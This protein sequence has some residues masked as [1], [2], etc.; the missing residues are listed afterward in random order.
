MSFILEA[1]KKSE[2]ARQRQT[3]PGLAG[4]PEKT[5]SRRTVV[6]PWVIGALLLVNAIIIGVVL[7]RDGPG[8]ATSPGPSASTSTSAGPT[9]APSPPGNSLRETEAP[10]SGRPPVPQASPP[11][12]GPGT[13][14]SPEPVISGPEPQ[15][16]T[17]GAAVRSLA[18]EARSPGETS[19][20]ARSEPR[21][22]SRTATADPATPV[23]APATTAPD[24]R[25]E[26]DPPDETPQPDLPD[27]QALYLSGELSGSPIN[28]DLHV[29]F[30]D[31]GRRVV[32][33]SGKRYREGDEIDAGLTVE[34][35]IPA[36][37]ILQRRGR[38]YLL[39]AN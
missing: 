38:N 22:V 36:G 24:P 13:T 26:P 19:P 37:V 3:G 30:P 12:A 4:L 9:A 23:P 6:W 27:V 5:Q 15:R 7:F 25:A 39:Q 28:L 14:T 31:P 29:Y 20:P 11:A 2:N 34:E 16:D 35:I 21:P 1:L 17:G 10:P 33:I 8:P 18:D 32:F